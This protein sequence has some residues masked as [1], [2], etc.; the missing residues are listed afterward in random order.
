[1]AISPAGKYLYAFGLKGLTIFSLPAFKKM[2]FLPKASLLGSGWTTKGQWYTMAG[3]SKV[4]LS[5]HPLRTPPGRPSSK[6][7]VFDLKR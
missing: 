4:M 7:V 6:F 1:M 2:T 3:S 5:L